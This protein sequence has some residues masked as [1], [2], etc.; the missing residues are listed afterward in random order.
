MGHQILSIALGAK[1]YKLKF[2]HRGSNHPVEDLVLEKIY[3]T[4]QIMGYA[5]DEQS[6]PSSV[7]GQSEKSQ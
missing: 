1:T 3:V 2:G 5:V 6:L 4:S 7:K